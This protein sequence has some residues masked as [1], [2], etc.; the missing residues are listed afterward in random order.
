MTRIKQ[1]R[2][3]F[4]YTQD[5]LAKLLNVSRFTVAMWETSSQEPDY[6]TLRNLSQM[7][8]VPPDFVVG[9]GIFKKWDQIIEYY[10]AVSCKLKF[11]FP[12]TLEMPSFCG[13]KN[14]SAWLDTRLYFEPD[15]LQ[16]VRWFSFAVRD[17]EITPTGKDPD[18]GLTAD[19]SVE[20]TPEFQALIDAEQLN[21]ARQQQHSANE[22]IL[23]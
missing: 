5:G 7:F 6:N 19:V 3:F 2:K 1:L 4:G 10:D 8:S 15:E 14:L 22:V 21:I 16:L 18:G 12:M 17:I 20:F 23:S 13:D 11:S 9:K